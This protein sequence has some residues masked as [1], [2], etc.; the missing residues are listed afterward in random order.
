[1]LGLKTDCFVGDNAFQSSVHIQSLVPESIAPSVICNRQILSR[2]FQPDC[3][4][5]CIK[6]IFVNAIYLLNVSKAVGYLSIMPCAAVSC[7]RKSLQKRSEI[8]GT[9]F[10]RYKLHRLRQDRVYLCPLMV[11]YLYIINKI[12]ANM[13]FYTLV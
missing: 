8:S 11:S 7:L 4:I 9:G 1:M 2:I 10:C 3:N 5:I 13:D 12:N 6:F